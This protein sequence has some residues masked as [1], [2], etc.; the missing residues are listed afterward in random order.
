MIISNMRSQLSFRVNIFRISS[1]SC[2]IFDLSSY[3]AKDNNIAK[4]DIKTIWSETQMVFLFY[5]LI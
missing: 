3:R 1:E 4:L 2:S 5:I